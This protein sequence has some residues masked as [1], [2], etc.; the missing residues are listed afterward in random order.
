LAAKSG[1]HVLLR[2][3]N[4]KVV[5]RMLGW[6]LLIFTIGLASCQALLKAEPAAAGFPAASYIPT[7][8]VH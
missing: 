4:V 2:I 8:A 1:N 3:L 5:L 6:V 7:S